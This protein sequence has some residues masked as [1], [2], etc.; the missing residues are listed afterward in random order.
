ML[1]SVP[2]CPLAV[3]SGDK[4]SAASTPKHDSQADSCPGYGG[5]ESELQAAAES[6]LQHAQALHLVAK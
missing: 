4:S 5:Q 1:T 3:D 2:G 6:F